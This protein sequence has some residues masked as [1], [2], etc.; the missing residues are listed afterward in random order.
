MQ[1][2]HPEK[3]AG[4]LPPEWFDV[5]KIY[6]PGLVRPFLEKAS[7][8]DEVKPTQKIWNDKAKELSLQ[9]YIKFMQGQFRN[10]AA[11][12]PRA[13][14]DLIVQWATATGNP[15]PT[16]ILALWLGEL[17]S[18]A[19]PDASP[20][21]LNMKVRNALNDSNIIGMEHFRSDAGCG[22]IYQ[23]HKSGNG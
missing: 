13:P 3:H 14:V 12:D 22:E 23:K 11:A 2:Q 4:S 9:K 18:L 10:L 21:T 19:H 6:D 15:P 16:A 17:L 1:N 5:T 7:L 20:E 8:P